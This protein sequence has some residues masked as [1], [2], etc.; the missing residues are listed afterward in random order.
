MKAVG[1]RL[2]RVG[3]ELPIPHVKLQRFCPRTLVKSEIWQGNREETAA[4]RK[5]KYL[6]VQDLEFRSA[7]GYTSLDGAIPRFTNTLAHQRIAAEPF[8]ERRAIFTQRGI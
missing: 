1:V 3:G 8:F 2:V 6:P 7:R 4:A 5:V